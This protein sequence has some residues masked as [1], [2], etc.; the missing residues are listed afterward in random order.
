VIH[1]HPI[2]IIVP[3]I[4]K[5]F[6]FVFIPVILYLYA[7]F[8]QTILPFYV[9]EIYLILIYIKIIYDIFDWYNDVWIVTE[10]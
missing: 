6:L 5:L 7:L 1:T 2:E 8:I 10:E 9:V 4:A 3:I